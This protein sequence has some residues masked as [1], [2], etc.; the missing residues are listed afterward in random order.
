MVLFDITL[1]LDPSNLH[2]QLKINFSL[3][4]Q[5]N[6]DDYVFRLPCDD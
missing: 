2:I 1:H 3:H 4:Q 6:L 5:L